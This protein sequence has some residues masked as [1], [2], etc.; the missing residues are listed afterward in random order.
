MLEGV[1]LVAIKSV[2]DE[3]WDKIRGQKLSLIIFEKSDCENCKELENDMISDDDDLPFS[4]AKLSL[5]TKGSSKIK[6]QNPWISSID[7][8]PFCALYRYGELIDSWSSYD[9]NSIKARVKEY[10]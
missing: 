4:I 10:L 8:L 6:M 1:L 7:L 2:D 3:T 5:D 9:F